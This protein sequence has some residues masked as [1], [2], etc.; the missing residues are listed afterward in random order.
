MSLTV[1]PSYQVVQR[2]TKAPR[3]VLV[4]TLRPL[5]H[6]RILSLGLD[7]THCDC[8]VETVGQQLSGP[9]SSFRTRNEEMV[10]QTVGHAAEGS[11]MSEFIKVFGKDPHYKV[12][13]TPMY[14]AVQTIAKVYPVYGVSGG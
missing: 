2:K 12:T 3:P 4:N 14:I 5:V 1:A 8:D 9:Y 11:E 6:G 7:Q 13:S 10:P